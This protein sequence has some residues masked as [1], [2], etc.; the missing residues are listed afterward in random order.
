MKAEA[1]QQFA[2]RRMAGAGGGFEEVKK[3]LAKPDHPGMANACFE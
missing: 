1:Y 2:A 3:P